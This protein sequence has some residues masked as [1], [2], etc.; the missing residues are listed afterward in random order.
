M[1]RKLMCVAVAVLA[2][3]VLGGCGGGTITTEGVSSVEFDGVVRNADGAALAGVEIIDART[4]EASITDS[5]G[6]FTLQAESAGGEAELL[7]SGENIN[8]TVKVTGLPDGDSTAVVELRVDTSSSLISVVSLDVS[9]VNPPHGDEV[10][11]PPAVTPSP[12]AAQRKFY[13]T[14]EGRLLLENGAP[15]PKAKIRVA[16]GTGLAK[17]DIDGDF[18]LRSENLSPAVVLTVNYL[19][20]EGSVRISGIPAEKDLVARI[21]LRLNL[22]SKPGMQQWLATKPKN[23]RLPLEI[24]A[25]KFQ[26]R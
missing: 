13:I 17:T 22:S 26:E 24:A 15:L 19:G 11:D 10:E 25:L 16:P 23:Q 7:L 18:S 4:G 21:T 12:A 5:E 8:E 3:A 20:H 2:L 1:A 9:E 6:R 14:F